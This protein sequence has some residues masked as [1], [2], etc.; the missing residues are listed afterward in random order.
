MGTGSM[1]SEDADEHQEESGYSTMNLTELRSV[2]ENIATQIRYH[3]DLITIVLERFR[4]HHENIGELSSDLKYVET[5]IFKSLPKEAEPS[6]DHQDEDIQ[7]EE[8]SGEQ[9]A[10][11]LDLNPQ[12]RLRSSASHSS[13]SCE[14]IPHR[15]KRNASRT[16]KTSWSSTQLVMTHVWQDETW[17]T[18]YEDLLNFVRF[19]RSQGRW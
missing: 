9:E 14:T 2:H 3:R 16:S 5:L 7:E 10:S 19:R 11:Q 4:R 12:S 15:E 8:D 17:D 18:K 1:S 6:D 13:P